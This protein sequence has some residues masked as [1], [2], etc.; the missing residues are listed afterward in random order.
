MSFFL[1]NSTSQSQCCVSFLQD[2]FSQIMGIHS[3]RNCVTQL[4][5][6]SYGKL[7]AKLFS[8]RYKWRLC[9][10]W[11]S[12]PL[13]SLRKNLLRWRL[14]GRQLLAATSSNWL[15]FSPEAILS[16]GC[17][18]AMIGH[19]WGSSVG[20]LLL[21]SGLTESFCSGAFHQSSQDFLR[22]TLQSETPSTQ[23]F[24]LPSLLSLELDRH[25]GLKAS[26]LVPSASSPL[27]PITPI[28]S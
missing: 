23:T 19:S 11:R 26:S 18:Q 5:Y 14:S 1:D 7:G 3:I 17:Y 24:F 25:H 2:L 13:I 9:Q 22:A 21:N 12:S 28:T 20:S 15:E 4:S 10:P 16:S 6:S 27:Y 8:Q